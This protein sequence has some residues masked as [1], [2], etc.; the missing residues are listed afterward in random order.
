MQIK[1][2]GDERTL[3]QLKTLIETPVGTVPY[4]REFGIDNSILDNP[5]PVAK[6]LYVVEVA[7]KVEKYIPN[8]SIEDVE[9]EYDNGKL[10]PK[11][12]VVVNE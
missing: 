9:F 3:K 1:Y 7:E 6:N 8:I 4:D 2:S 11:V 5:L 12:V 10:K